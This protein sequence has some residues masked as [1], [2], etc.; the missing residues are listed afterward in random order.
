MS[1]TDST[2]LKISLPRTE[3][4]IVSSGAIFLSFSYILNI[5]LNL[6]ISIK[7]KLL[8]L[9]I[10]ALLRGCVFF[11]TFEFY[12]FTPEILF[13][14]SWLNLLR[15]LEKERA[16]ST[17]DD[18]LFVISPKGFEWRGSTYEARLKLWGAFS[19]ALWCFWRAGTCF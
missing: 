13:F 2:L 9:S 4:R 17:P 1:A 12:L 19:F 16:F 3:W 11:E 14:E 18:I 5:S 8:F 15:T 7:T 6:L 10:N